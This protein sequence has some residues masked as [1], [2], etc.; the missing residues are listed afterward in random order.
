MEELSR[1]EGMRGDWAKGKT[2]SAPQLDATSHH[3]VTNGSGHGQTPWPDPVRPHR[4]AVHCALTHLG[5]TRLAPLPLSLVVIKPVRVTDLQ[6]VLSMTW[7]VAKKPVKKSRQAEQH[8]NDVCFLLLSVTCDLC[9]MQ[10]N[11]VEV[12]TRLWKPNIRRSWTIGELWKA[13]FRQTEDSAANKA[14]TKEEVQD[15]EA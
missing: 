6:S 2:V 13:Q 11:L 1:G 5:S 15:M 8:K 10:T 14:S 12:I 3:I 7:R 4:L 9:Y